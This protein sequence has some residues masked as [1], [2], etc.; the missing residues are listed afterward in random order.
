MAVSE[1]EKATLDLMLTRI[2]DELSKGN[3]PEVTVVYF[4][5]DTLKAGGAY[6]EYT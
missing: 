5:P 1:Y 3:H 2:E 4:V 6:E